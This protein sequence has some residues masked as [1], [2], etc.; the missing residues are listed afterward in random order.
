MSYKN[1][2]LAYKKQK[3]ERQVVGKIKMVSAYEAVV[4]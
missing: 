3:Y 1:P 2:N 4:P